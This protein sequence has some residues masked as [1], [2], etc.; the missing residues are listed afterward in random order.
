MA[1]IIVKSPVTTNGRDPFLNGGQQVFKTTIVE[2][3][4]GPLFEKMNLKL[5]DHLKR[6]IA[7]YPEP[8]IKPKKNDKE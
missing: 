2:A 4:A 5:P 1:Q 8:E 7:P 3:A 6:V